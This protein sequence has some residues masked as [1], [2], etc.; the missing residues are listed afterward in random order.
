MAL[1]L[2]TS[3]DGFAV[4]RAR[5]GNA[6]RELYDGE[7]TRIAEIGDAEIIA[8]S[9]AGQD[10]EVEV[11]THG[12]GDVRRF[13]NIDTGAERTEATRRQRFLEDRPPRRE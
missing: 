9:G 3:H 2:V 11:T 7:P 10:R 13:R 6:A 4:V 12:D 1:Y 8:V 5:N